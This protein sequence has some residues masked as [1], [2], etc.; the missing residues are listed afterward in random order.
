MD[1]CEKA[2]P[3]A[4]A[5]GTHGACLQ[6]QTKIPQKSFRRTNDLWLIQHFQRFRL[7]LFSLHISTLPLRI[8]NSLKI[9]PIIHSFPLKTCTTNPYQNKTLFNFNQLSKICVMEL[10]LTF[11]SYTK[12]KYDILSSI[13]HTFFSENF[14]EIL[15][16][17]YLEGIWER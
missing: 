6:L 14:D 9:R 2:I 5:R 8:E 7:K 15:P 1:I 17:L 4:S 16:A 3:I 13:V 12:L 11:V 10:F